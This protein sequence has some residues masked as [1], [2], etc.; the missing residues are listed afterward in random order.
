[1]TTKEI[2]SLFHEAIQEKAIYN[3]L[4]GITRNH[5]CNWLNSRGAKPTV[6]EMLNVLYQLKKISITANS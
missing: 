6:G 5:I 3:K 4:E 1:M 2:E